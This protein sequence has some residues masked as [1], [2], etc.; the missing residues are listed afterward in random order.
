MGN[1]ILKSKVII[2]KILKL[3]IYGAII[4]SIMKLYKCI[5]IHF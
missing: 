3:T 5:D 1:S 4:A 2:A